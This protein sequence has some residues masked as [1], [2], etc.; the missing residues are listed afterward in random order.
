MFFVLTFI[1]LVSC[2]NEVVESEEGD[3]D[4]TEPEEF[5]N[6]ELTDVDLELVDYTYYE[7]TDQSVGEETITVYAEVKNTSEVDVAPGYVD[8]TYLDSEDSVISV[9]EA[10]MLPSYIKA[11]GTGYLSTEIEDDI[12]EFNDL[13][14]IQFEFFPESAED[15]LVFE[16]DV[17]KQELKFD[18]FGEDGTAISVVGFIENDTDMDFGKDDTAAVV[19]LYDSEDNFVAVEEMYSDQGISVEADNETSFKLGSG[20][21]LPNELA[22]LVDHA[23]VT[24][25]AYENNDEQ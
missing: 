7:W 15:E 4:E 9:N 12:S 19:G 25:I 21:P 8:V 20:S 3:F 11:G 5:E 14:D 13:D 23:K 16:L 1:F 6:S 2:S 18:D 22:D 17:K 10:F 24:S